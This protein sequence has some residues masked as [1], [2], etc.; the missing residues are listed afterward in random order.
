MCKVLGD[1]L[2][3]NQNKLDVNIKHGTQS[4]KKILI[5]DKK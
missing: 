1:Y 4:Q 3:I 5:T 2:Q